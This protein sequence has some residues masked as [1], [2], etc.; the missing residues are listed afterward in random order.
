[1]SIVNVVDNYL[2]LENIIKKLLIE[3]WPG[4]YKMNLE[5]LVIPESKEA[6]QN[7]QHYVKRLGSQFDEDYI[8]Q[9]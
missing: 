5:H 7:C 8:K 4:V 2:I 9:R 1:M 3:Y 6:L